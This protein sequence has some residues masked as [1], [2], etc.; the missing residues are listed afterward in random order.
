MPGEVVAR[1]QIRRAIRLRVVDAAEASGFVVSPSP[2]G[3]PVFDG[4][5]DIDYQCG[6]CGEVLCHGVRPG[7]FSG[8]MIGC[9]CGAFNHVPP[10]SAVLGGLQATAR[11][12]EI[13]FPRESW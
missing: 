5:G 7:L 1:V 3:T 10:E 11:N 2:N 9:R 12:T 6:A 4:P 13:A 8:V